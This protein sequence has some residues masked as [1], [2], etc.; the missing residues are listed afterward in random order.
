[1]M[2]FFPDKFNKPWIHSWRKRV[3]GIAPLRRLKEE[4]KETK[5]NNFYKKFLQKRDHLRKDTTIHIHTPSLN[6][7]IYV[8]SLSP[9]NKVSSCSISL[10][11]TTT[12]QAFDSDLTHLTYFLFLTNSR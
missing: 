5:L 3:G 2:D 6:L 12:N 4:E 9:T 8:V 10:P 11:P 7:H 1:M